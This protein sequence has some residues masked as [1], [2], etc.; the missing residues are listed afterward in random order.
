MAGSRHNGCASTQ[1]ESV[2]ANW[3]AGRVGAHRRR[4][5]WALAMALALLP[6]AEAAA[7]DAPPICRGVDTALLATGRTEEF[8][9][10]SE[11]QSI[12]TATRATDAALRGAGLYEEGS[13]RQLRVML[14]IYG[15]DRLVVYDVQGEFGSP[16]GP[17]RGLFHGPGG[18]WPNAY[19]TQWEIVGGG[20]TTS[21]EQVFDKVLAAV[22]KVLDEFLVDAIEICG[23]SERGSPPNPAPQYSETSSASCPSDPRTGCSTAVQWN[24]G[25]V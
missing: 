16:V 10:T 23:G 4:G 8:L 19:V 20:G 13:P 17:T 14:T 11:L 15:N 25:P 9:N 21:P 12:G 1:R 5:H 6:R 2:A 22:R 7:Q 3:Y 18:P 24:R